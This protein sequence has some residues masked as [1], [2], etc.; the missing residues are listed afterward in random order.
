MIQVSKLEKY[1]Q[2]KR[3]LHGLD[4]DIPKGTALGIIGGSGSGKTTLMRCIN[5]L[6]RFE[7]G[8]VRCAEVD[9]TPQLSDKDYKQRVQD[10]RR[11][12]GM[13][14]QHLYLFPHMTALQNIIEAPVHVAL[15]PQDQ[16]IAEGEKWLERFGIAHTA[17]RRP[18][19]LSGGEQQRVAIIRALMMKPK[20]LFLDEPT[21]ALDPKRSSDVREIFR[22]FVEEG[23]TLVLVTHSIRFLRGLA[24]QVLYMESG[25]VV[26][27]GTAEQVLESP[28]DERTRAF[29]EHA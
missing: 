8:H 9:L 15:R 7:Q 16:V 17:H 13:V 5:G 18:E 25:E 21:S 10:L 6:L 4:V 24:D 20:I 27:S 22:G 12:V 26:E 2:G 3:V 29:L 23:S 1:F 14:F 28:K 11:H 19:A